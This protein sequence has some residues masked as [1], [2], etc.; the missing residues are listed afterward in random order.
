MNTQLVESLIQV[1]N[2][3]SPAERNL[4]AQKLQTQSEW[5]AMPNVSIEKEK[6]NSEHSLSKTDSSEY[7]LRGTVT[8]YDD[9]M[10]P[11]TSPEDWGV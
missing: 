6:I 10:E 5:E 2:S 8:R 7:S 9:P 1:I 11:A 3:L 4:L